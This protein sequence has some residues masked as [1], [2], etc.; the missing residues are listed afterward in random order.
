M[1][2]TLTLAQQVRG[3]L[4][5]AYCAPKNTNKE[6]DSDLASTSAV[7]NSRSPSLGASRSAISCKI[8]SSAA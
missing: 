5:R 4:A 7:I 2:E 1:T 8:S 6:L 3:A